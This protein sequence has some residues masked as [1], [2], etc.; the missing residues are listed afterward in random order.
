MGKKN[1]ARPSTRAGS[2]R[3]AQAEPGPEA[4]PPVTAERLRQEIDPESDLWG[5]LFDPART[6]DWIETFLT[7]PNERGE[8]VRFRL[9]PQQ[10]LMLANQTGRDI[11]VKGRQTRASSL[12]LARTLRRMTT[13]F[14]LTALVLT[15]DD[16]TTALFRAR[17]L[18]HLRDL[19]AAGLPYRLAKSN[20]DEL[21]LAGLENRFLF[22]SAGQRVVGRAITAHIVHASEVAFWKDAGRALGGILPAVPD[23]PYGWADLE[24]TPNGAE[25]LFY[26]YVQSS[27]PMNPTG[28]WQTHFYPWWLEPR[29]SID[30]MEDNEL[31]PGTREVLEKFRKEFVP[32]DEERALAEEYGLT[33][34]QLIWRRLRRQE[35]L[36]TGVPFE[37]EYPESL[38]GCFLQPSESFFAST[39]GS[40]H[41]SWYESQIADPVQ[42]LGSLPFRDSVVRFH[43]DHLHVW[44]FPVVDHVYVVYVDTGAGGQASDPSVAIVLDARSRTHVATLSVRVPPRLFAEMVAAVASWY[45]TATIGGERDAWGTQVL[46][47]LRELQYPRIFYF[48][49]PEHPE[50]PAEPWIWPGANRRNLLLLSFQQAVF[51][52]LFF[53]RDRELVKE[54]RT[55]SWV[56]VQNRQK[57][58]A[59]LNQHDDRVMAAAGA[60]WMANTV[61]YSLP[62]KKQDILYVD[63][64]GIVIRS[65]NPSGVK[66]WFR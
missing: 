37:Q 59:T 21:V 27:R 24:S 50:R 22:A 47:R 39:D 61:P 31:A 23:P 26:E 13:G 30:V 52:H 7:I 49:D 5:L 53:T 25:G 12:F 17:I 45:N 46:E 64:H 60:F 8:I 35:L 33:E 10:K 18:H 63:R 11:T 6:R 14:G 29:Y 62:E 58:M 48:V 3:R 42:K 65:R 20:E 4:I 1:P 36:R 40:D 32:D 19:Q 54:M 28:L 56:K 66:P 41:L 43:G 16:A 57:A 15:H 9:Y 51:S 38:E 44:E 55:F 2:R 34:G